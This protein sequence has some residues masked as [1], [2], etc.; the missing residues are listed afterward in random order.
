MKISLLKMRMLTNLIFQ[1]KMLMK[2]FKFK[3]NLKNRL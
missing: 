2:S 1:L 3:L